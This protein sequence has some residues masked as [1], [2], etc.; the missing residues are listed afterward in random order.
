MAQPRTVIIGIS[1]CS[2]SGK[3]TLARLLR[4]IF[5]ETFILHEDD[6]YKPESELP[7]KDGFLDWDCLEAISIPDL[8][9]ALRHIRETG[10]VPP[11]LLSIQDLN[12]V[13]PCPATPSQIADCAARVRAWL[14]PGQPGSLIFPGAASH[15]PSEPA[16]GPNPNNPNPNSDQPQPPAKRPAPPT[17]LCILEGFLLYAPRPHPLAEHV[18]S[19]LDIKL[20]LRASREAA[21]RRRAA[22]DGYVTLEGFWKDPPGYVERVVWPNYV[23]AHRWLFEGGVVEGGRVDAAVLAREG[24]R[25]VDRVVRRSGEGGREKEGEGEVV[26][27]EQEEDVE[28]GKV[29][30]W[31]V[32]VV[33][34]ELERICLPRNEVGK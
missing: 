17:R 11:T 29:L 22:R 34:E 13:G 7:H 16:T 3:T 27:V 28:F 5:P 2:S 15:P 12:S 8:E 25:V 33:M 31:A 10:S 23:D 26:E 6:F 18:T 9:A 14:S 4:D 21:L 30:E 32:R 19:L 24:I 20:F 1:G